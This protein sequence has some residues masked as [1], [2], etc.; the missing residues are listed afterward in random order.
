MAGFIQQKFSGLRTNLKF[1]NW[2]LLLLQRIFYRHLPVVVY[3][4][5]GKVFITDFE[6]GDG[7]GARQLLSTDMYSRYF[8]L[9]PKRQGLK[10]LDLGAN[11]G[12]FPLCLHDNGID[13]SKVVCVEMNPHT[14]A[15]LLFNV[16][17]NFPR[18]VTAVNA[19]VTG[20][21]AAVEISDTRGGTGQSIYC[22]D[23]G[24]NGAATIEVPGV[25]LEALVAQHFGE[26]DDG[27][28]DLVKIDVE[29][30]EHEILFSETAGVLR[31]FRSM[32]I[33]I[34]RGGSRTQQGVVEKIESFGFQR[35][36]VPGDGDS[37]SAGEDAGD[38]VMFF[39][40]Q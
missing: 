18:S 25:T 6:G 14:Y 37:C 20:D 33:E 34:H 38:E 31:R 40:R 7:A 2:P 11:G 13:F 24:E 23:A 15:R 26:G 35:V 21:G 30:A 8:S 10:I 28:L 1:A 29:G 3:Q 12:G 19:A 9:L 22:A 17:R 27:D 32:I 16:D 36:A 39:Q 5:K 4:R